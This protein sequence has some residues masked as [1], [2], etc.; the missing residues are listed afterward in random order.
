MKSKNIIY[1]VDFQGISVVKSVS[2]SL[3]TLP[4]ERH[5]L[6]QIGD[7]HLAQLYI[8]FLTKKKHNNKKQNKI[9]SQTNK[10]LTI[11]NTWGK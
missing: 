2:K 4:C 3:R 6:F 9:K 5:V 1:L 7:L 11:I 8:T 10:N